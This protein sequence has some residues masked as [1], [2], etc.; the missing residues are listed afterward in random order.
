MTDSYLPGA[1]VLGHSLR[2]KG[3]KGRLVACVVIEKLAAETIKELQVSV[4][5]RDGTMLIRIDCLR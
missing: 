5:M 3:A 4:E 1:L 2:D